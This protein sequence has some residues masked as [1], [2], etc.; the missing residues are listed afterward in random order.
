MKIL[1]EHAG[2]G[3]R[4]PVQIHYLSNDARIGMETL[5]EQ[6][7]GKYDDL[8]FGWPEQTAKLRLSSRD[9][10]EIPADRRDLL[11]FTSVLGR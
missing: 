8:A 4:T 9:F 3:N 10:P 1:G 2:Y 6:V 7:V 5:L 11:I